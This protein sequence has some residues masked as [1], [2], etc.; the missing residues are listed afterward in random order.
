M[1]T[2][3]QHDA[4]TETFKACGCGIEYTETEYFKLDYVGDWDFG[5][6]IPTLVLH[7][8]TCGSTIAVEKKQ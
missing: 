5:P 7:N 4:A 8:C 1:D 6:T 3:Q 2:T